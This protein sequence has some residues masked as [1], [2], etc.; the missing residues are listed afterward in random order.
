MRKMPAI[1]TLKTIHDGGQ[2]LKDSIVQA[3]KLYVPQREKVVWGT[4]E[5]SDK[6]Q[7]DLQDELLIRFRYR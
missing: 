5:K 3:G 6:L 1:L 7:H 4:S 2:S